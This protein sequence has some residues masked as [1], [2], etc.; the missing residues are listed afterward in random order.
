MLWSR[1]LWRDRLRIAALIVAMVVASASVVAGQWN[2]RTK[3]VFSDAVMVPGATLQ[4]GTYIFRL[5]DS[6]SSRHLV[7]ISRENGEVIT[8]TQAVPTKRMEA[9]GDT[10]LKFNPTEA[11]SPPALAAWFYPGTIYGHQFVYPEEQARKIAQRTKTIVLSTDVPGTDLQRGQLRVYDASGS[12]KAWQPDAAAAASWEA[13]QRGRRSTAGI[14][15]ETAKG[16]KRRASAPAVDAEFQGT[17]VTLDNLE[18]NPTKYVGQT[19]SVDAEVED[20]YGPRMFTIDEPN[21]GDLQGEMLVYMPTSLAAMVRENDRVTVTGVV[22][23]FVEADVEREWGWLGL[24]DALEI[25]LGKRT[26]LVANRIV[27]GNNNVAMVVKIASGTQAVGTSGRAGAPMADL[28]AIGRADEDMIGR[29]ANLSGV[30]VEAVAR[31]RGFFAKAGD[32]LVFVLP[33]ADQQPAVRQGDT[34]TLEGVILQM[35]RHMKD[36]LNAP[37]G[38]FNDDVYIYATQLKR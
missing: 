4:P 35:P 9:K 10:V 17:R 28:N 25:E 13:W 21:W 5:M 24:D 11:G 34:V 20:V 37:A 27:G 33:A 3:L 26:V 15:S 36:R 31:D 18:D 12:P 2:E 16:E 14:V 30:R 6:Q 23:R 1:M 32:R 22:K 7:E 38:E 29:H 8:V 19:V